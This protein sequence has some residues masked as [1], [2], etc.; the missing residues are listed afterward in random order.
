VLEE[1]RKVW[2]VSGVDELNALIGKR[3]HAEI[4]FENFG[5]I[6]G[7]HVLNQTREFEQYGQRVRVPFVIFDNMVMNGYVT[8]FSD[9]RNIIGGWAGP[10]M[11]QVRRDDALR[12]WTAITEPERRSQ[13]DELIRKT[14]A[15]DDAAAKLNPF[16]YFEGLMHRLHRR[17][18]STLL[19]SLQARG[20][21]G[22]ELRLAFLDELQNRHVGCVQA[23]EARHLIDHGKVTG[24]RYEMNAAI[25]QPLFGPDPVT[26]LAGVISPNIG[27]KDNG[28]GEGNTHIMKGLAAWM[29]AHA[30][31]IRGLDRSRPLL[32][33]FDLLTDQQIRS[34]F[35]T[36]DPLA[37]PDSGQ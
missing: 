15:Q 10:P 29:N 14:S 17:A 32:P 12:A 6:L 36:L 11:T 1:A 13:V 37:P 4:R 33:Q 18:H 35:R 2:G 22:P 30:S 28:S 7:H 21:Q 25:A 31:E 8:W 5:L 3:F 24:Y 26:C 27:A 20:L 23:H 34:A 9:G 16:G 19:S